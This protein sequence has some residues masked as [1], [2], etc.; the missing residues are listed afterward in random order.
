MAEHAVVLYGATGFTGGLVADHLA[1][2]ADTADGSWALA[3]RNLT[4]LRAVR[5][6]LAADRPELADLA[7]IEADA[8]DPASLR[9][10]AESAGVVI[11]TVGP[12]IR[13]GEGLVAA[14][15]AAGTDYVD[16]TGEP[17]FVDLM[18]LRHHAQAQSTGARLVH[19]CGFDSVP[20]DLGA[21]FTVEQLPEGEPLTVEGFVRA[22][23]TISGGTFDS[24]LEIM[25]RLGSGR[26]V[27]AQRRRA[28][29]RP[30]DRRVHGVTGPPHRDAVAGGWV[31]PAPT[32][33]P[34]IVLRSARALPRYGPDF[35]YG[36]WITTGNVAGTAGLIAGAGVL[37][38][39]AQVG[40]AR[41]ALGRLRPPGEGPDEARRA[42]SWF[43]IR[44]A[45]RVRSE[46]EPRVVCEVAGGDPGY[47]ETAKMLAES[48][49]CLAHDELPPTAGQV[50]IAQAMGEALT[51]RL[52]RA[53]ITFTVTT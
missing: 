38:A 21:R 40:P 37:A 52:Q 22:G 1:G 44:F 9:R 33:D 49:L 5:D 27:A 13:Y 15:A 42:R 3:G 18:Y 45:G 11:S 41:R 19:A 29:P 2:H 25:G 14:C 6:R 35:G 4:R 23:G 7:L 26:R 36:H 46:R 17:E 53:G 24:A 43:T 10:L 39:L 34:Q 30:G 32:I 20:H 16:L 28:E 31:V 47:G 8:S 50:T 12:Y 48:A 51:A